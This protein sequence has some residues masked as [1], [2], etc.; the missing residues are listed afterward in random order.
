MK[1][2]IDMGGSHIAIATVNEEGRIVEKVEQDLLKDQKNT[3]YIL[4]Y[5]DKAIE[6]LSKTAN[7][8]EI[9]IACPGNAKGS[10]IQN[11]VNLSISEIDFKELE[12]KYQVRIKSINDAKAAAIAEKAYGVLNTSKDGVFLCLGTGIGGAVFLNNQL[13]EANRNPGFELG[14]M[15]IEKEGIECKC[16]KRGCFETYCSMKRFKENIK[17][18]LEVIAPEENIENSVELKCI[19]ERHMHSMKINKIVQT[20]INDLVIGLSNVIDI[21]EPEIICL[22]GSF[23]YFE[24]ILYKGLMKEMKNRKYVFNKEELPKIELAKLGNDAGIIGATLI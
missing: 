20:Y 24:D 22:G 10:K 13:L 3:Q 16:G 1:I 4:N 14:H 6:K 19:L 9:G 12:T 11:L 23:V 17:R 21:F 5:V 18:V 8:N 2:G 7:I 15:V